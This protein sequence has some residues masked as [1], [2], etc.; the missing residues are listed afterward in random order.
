M[1]IETL[2]HERQDDTLWY[3]HEFGQLYWLKQGIIVVKTEQMQWTITPGTVGFIPAKLPHSAVALT[4]LKGYLFHVNPTDEMPFPSA[5]NVYTSATFIQSLLQKA[6]QLDPINNNATYV[7]HL[8][9]LL[10]YEIAEA[11]TLPLSLPLPC[12]RR[13]L[14][15]AETLLKYPE[16]HMTQVQLAKKWGLSVRTLSRVFIQQT[17]LSFSLWRQQAKILVSLQWLHAGVPINEVAMLS[18]YNNVSSYI[19]VFR[20]RF[21]ETPGQFQSRSALSIKDKSNLN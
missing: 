15:I 7:K 4:T 21:G 19:N 10:S 17:G 11:K 16:N 13:A 1:L 14:H 2:S 5:P 20:Q 12:D 6:I 18:G 9:A 3:C 8:T